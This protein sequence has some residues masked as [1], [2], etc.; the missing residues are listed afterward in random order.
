MKEIYILEVLMGLTVGQHND[1][2]WRQDEAMRKISFYSPLIADALRGA[3]ILKIS[4]ELHDM[5]KIS[6]E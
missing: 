5:G 4:K 1:M 3:I 6:D 2:L